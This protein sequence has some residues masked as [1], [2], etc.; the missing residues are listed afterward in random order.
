[1]YT[2][3]GM[4]KPKTLTGKNIKNFAILQITGIAKN[5]ME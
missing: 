2:N 5:K 3:L 1:M 4:K